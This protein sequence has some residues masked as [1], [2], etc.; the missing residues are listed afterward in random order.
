MQAQHLQGLKGSTG[1]EL[2]GRLAC[3]W[4]NCRLGMICCLS[5]SYGAVRQEL[6]IA[7]DAAK[8]TSPK[9]S[10]SCS[11]WLLLMSHMWQANA[12]AGR[13]KQEHA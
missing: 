11:S 7:C 5:T 6:D 4:S 2:E 12:T 8:P 3:V 13:E 1:F 9:C 10:F